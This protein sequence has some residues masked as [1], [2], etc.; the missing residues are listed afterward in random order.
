MHHNIVR[1]VPLEKEIL[2]KN[3][4]DIIST[5]KPEKTDVEKDITVDTKSETEVTTFNETTATTKEEVVVEDEYSSELINITQKEE[6]EEKTLDT[7][8]VEEDLDSYINNCIKLSY[9]D[10]AS[11]K[12][13]DKEIDVIFFLNGFFRQLRTQDTIADII[14]NKNML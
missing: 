14:Q 7:S 11:F 8:I 10:N 1:Q 12:Q 5:V 2:T 3:E 13:T 4:N 6:N 9:V